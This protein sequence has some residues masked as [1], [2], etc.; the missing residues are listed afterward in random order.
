M[1]RTN[2]K[3][4]RFSSGTLLNQV[5]PLRFGATNRKWLPRAAALFA[6]IIAIFLSAATRSRAY[7]P[8]YDD[9]TRLSA[10]PLALGQA[11]TA[12]SDD[13][14][15][16]FYNPAA[17]ANQHRFALMHNHSARH[18]PKEVVTVEVDQLDGDTQAVIVPLNPYLTAGIGFNFQGEMGYDYRPLGA[19]DGTV[20]ELAAAFPVERFAGVERVEG[21]GLALSPWTQLGA[22][23]RSFFHMYDR[24]A[25]TARTLGNSQPTFPGDIGPSSSELHWRR[26]GD[27]HSL[28]FRQWIAPGVFLSGC[29]GKADFDY[30][31]NSSGRI[32][33]E[34]SGFS[35]HPVGWLTIVSECETVHYE[36]RDADGSA[37]E[38]LTPLTESRRHS[39]VEI[40]LAGLARLRFGGLHGE[41]TCGFEWTL[42]NLKLHYAEAKGY[43]KRILGT[44]PGLMDAVHIYGFVL[45]L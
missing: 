16:V 15:A 10:R 37:C 17:L 36:W 40:N 27:G 14:S 3:P 2:K 9:F 28:G 30:D 11:G 44:D 43:L 35:I 25:S 7:N 19:R 22:S 42:P 45:Y 4:E 29:S 20:G 33:R 13:P 23:R 24:P 18:L 39:G 31:D 8:Y 6:V 5:V 32:K 34:S 21:M 12:L 41:R 1:Q 38:A 26:M